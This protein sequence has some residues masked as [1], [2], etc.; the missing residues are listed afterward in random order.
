MQSFMLYILY[1]VFVYNTV[2]CIY[3]G[4]F[5]TCPP[6]IVR[7]WNSSPINTKFLQSPILAPLNT[8]IIL[9]SE[10]ILYQNSQGLSQVLVLRGAS[11]TL[12]QI[13]VE[14]GVSSIL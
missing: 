3:T 10:Q 11:L 5:F 2:S 6:Y 4:Y 9:C 7:V 8:K 13:C 12:N 14:G 1:Y